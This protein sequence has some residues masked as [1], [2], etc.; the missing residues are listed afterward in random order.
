MSD[1][2]TWATERR[3]LRDLVLDENNANKGT[4]RGIHMLEHSLR[5]YGAGRSILLDKKGRVIAGNKTV[6]RAADLGLDEVLVIQTDGTRLVAVQ[7]IDLD[8]ETDPAAR[9]M[10]YAD[11]RVGEID[12]AYDAAQIVAD[13]GDGLDLSELFFENEL[14]ELLAAQLAEPKETSAAR[15]LGDGPH[16]IKPVLYADE[17]AV[18]ERALKATGEK[19]RGRALIQVCEAYLGEGDEK[20][21]FDAIFKSIT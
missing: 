9:G 12:L 4:E 3:K 2:L 16:Q 10:A 17:V 19:N 21:Q 5:E 18:F 6:E 11:N 20:G 15:A 14:E 13:L 1:K 7:R 8:L